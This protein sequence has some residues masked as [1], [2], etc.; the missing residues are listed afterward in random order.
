M[1]RLSDDLAPRVEFLA[2]GDVCTVFGGFPFKAELFNTDGVGLPVVRIR[3]VNTAFSRTYYSGPFDPRWVVEDGD[4]LIGMDGDFRATRWMHGR[5]LLNQR[6]CRLQDFATGIDPS[7]V[8]YQVQVQLDRIHS[9]T[10]GS[11]VKHLSSRELQ[12]SRIPVPPLEVQREIVRILDRFTALEADLEAK[13]EAELHARRRQYALYRSQT[14]AQTGQS[15]NRVAIGRLGRIVTGRT[16]SS[17]DATAW[18][19][20]VDFVTPG[21]IKNGMRTVVSTSRRLSASGAASLAKVRI[22][23]GSILVTC[24][25]A[26]MGK[27]V[28]NANDCVPNQ[29]INAVIP[30]GEVEPGYLFHALSALRDELRRQGES[31]GGTLPLINKTAFSKIEVSLPSLPDQ[32]RAARILD[33]LHAVFEDLSVALPA[34]LT[35]RRKQQTYFRDKLL[36]FPEVP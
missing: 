20:Q 24:I 22:P 29:Q 21:D 33:R 28:I 18:G 35:A 6:V 10:A 2:V 9:S 15:A 1:T 8:M 34:E 32:R 31:G 27:T 3:D 25:G 26:D 17:P 14:L 13:L 30:A 36:A 12:K 4:I 11:T 23:A 19:D 16:P 7:Y 5:A